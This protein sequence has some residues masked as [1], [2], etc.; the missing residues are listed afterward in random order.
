M[1]TESVVVLRSEA[2]VFHP[3]VLREP[4]PF[5]RVVFYR[6]ELVHELS[7]FGAGSEEAPAHLFVVPGQRI[8]PP[9]HE[10][11]EFMRHSHFF[12][13]REKNIVQKKY[14]TKKLVCK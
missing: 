8:Y 4:D 1:G 7:I 9:V 12:F 11:S 5:V 3:G 6:V 2:D 10:H 14:T 13:L